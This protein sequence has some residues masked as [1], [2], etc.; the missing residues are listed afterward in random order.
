[1]KQ[2]NFTPEAELRGDQGVDSQVHVSV[3]SS[4]VVADEETTGG[5]EEVGKGALVGGDCFWWDGGCGA[6]EDIVGGWL[7]WGGFVGFVER[8]GGGG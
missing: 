8:G 1:M 5:G 3:Y 4:V 7:F 6:V 2:D